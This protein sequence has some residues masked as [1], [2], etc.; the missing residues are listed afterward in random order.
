MR[1]KY[2][3]PELDVTKF[4]VNKAIL[5]GDQDHGDEISD[6]WATSDPQTT[7]GDFDW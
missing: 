2:N 7:A 4:E 3:S 6:S 1:K 5:A